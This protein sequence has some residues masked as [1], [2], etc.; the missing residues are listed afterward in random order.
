MIRSARLSRGVV[1]LLIITKCLP[2]KYRMNDDAGYT[3]REVPV[4]NSKS[5]SDMAL[6]VLVMVTSSSGSS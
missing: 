6:M 5:D 3:V 4:T 2:L 1:E